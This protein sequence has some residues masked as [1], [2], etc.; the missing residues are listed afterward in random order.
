MKRLAPRKIDPPRLLRDDENFGICTKCE[1][2]W[3]SEVKVARYNRE[4]MI[5]VG[6]A[7]PRVTDQF[8]VL[9]CLKCGEIHEPNNMVSTTHIAKI[10]NEFTVESDK[11]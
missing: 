11:K 3:F 1:S 2:T 8:I 6:M 9:Q 10:Y 5:V 7:P 4:K